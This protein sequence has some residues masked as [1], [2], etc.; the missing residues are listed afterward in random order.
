MADL[1]INRKASHTPLDSTAPARHFV[2]LPS[3]ATF[4]QF[5]NNL[6]VAS[7]N[8][9]KAT[10]TQNADGN[11][12]NLNF[13]IFGYCYVR[14]WPELRV[15]CVSYMLEFPQRWVKVE[16]TGF[17]T[18]PLCLKFNRHKLPQVDHLFFNCIINIPIIFFFLSWQ[19]RSHTWDRFS[20][21]NF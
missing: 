5:F 14:W 11:V 13:D 20:F 17:Q 8:S 6:I 19:L 10:F 15:C 16:W 18:H 21:S 3:P 9:N 12:R 1:S 4:P 2:V 7:W